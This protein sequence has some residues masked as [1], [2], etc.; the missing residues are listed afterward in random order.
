M[1][2]HPGDGSARHD[3]SMPKADATDHQFRE[4]RHI[5]EAGFAGRCGVPAGVPSTTGVGDPAEAENVRN[6]EMH[7]ERQVDAR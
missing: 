1:F 4:G 2:E 7:L 6:Q 3:A 5:G